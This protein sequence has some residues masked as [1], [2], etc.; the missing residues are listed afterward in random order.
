MYTDDFR[1]STY[2]AFKDLYRAIDN[3]D[4]DLA[5]VC[6]WSEDFGLTIN[7]NKS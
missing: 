2:T 7:P 1:I 3:I 5:T 4:A 6:D